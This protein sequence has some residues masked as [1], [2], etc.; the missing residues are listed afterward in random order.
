MELQAILDQFEFRPDPETTLTRAVTDLRG[1]VRVLSDAGA[2]EAATATAAEVESAVRTSRDR[3]E[4]CYGIIEAH[5]FAS[6]IIEG[7]TAVD[8]LDWADVARVVGDDTELGRRL[9]EVF[10]IVPTGDEAAVTTRIETERLDLLGSVPDRL[11]DPDGTLPTEGNDLQRAL[12]LVTAVAYFLAGFGTHRA[13]SEPNADRVYAGYWL[14]AS[15]IVG[16]DG[17]EG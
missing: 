17:E 6:P 14:L 8:G 4:T 5:G 9:A 11:P 16:I 15:V 3:I 7:A 10:D 2:A 1:V 13:E 12:L